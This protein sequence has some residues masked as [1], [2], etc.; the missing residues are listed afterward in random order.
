MKKIV[1]LA[2]AAVMGLGLFT[3]T[4]AAKKYTIAISEKGLPTNKVVVLEKEAGTYALSQLI[5]I[6]REL[7]DTDGKTY[8]YKATDELVTIKDNMTKEVTFTKGSEVT[9]KAPAEKLGLMLLF[10]DGDKQV[11]SAYLEHKDVYVISS[12]AKYLLATEKA[13]KDAGYQYV[14]SNIE[15]DLLKHDGKQLKFATI[16]VTGPSEKIQ[17]QYKAFDMEGRSLFVQAF[18]SEQPLNTFVTARQVA[19]KYLAGY[20]VLSEDKVNDQPIY[21]SKA[22]NLGGTD[23][24]PAYYEVAKAKQ[25]LAPTTTAQATKPGQVAKTGELA[26]VATGIGAILTLA[27]AAFATIKRR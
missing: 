20:W 17:V 13:L 26:S 15:G 16:K 19:E 18:T 22:Y 6:E 4:Q 7:K 11:A 12:E 3:Y 9:G 8:E 10:L 14:S 21:L 5:D 25:P 24:I 23:F 1:S 2:L 27:G